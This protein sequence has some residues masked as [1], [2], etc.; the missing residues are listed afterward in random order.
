VM[1]SRFTEDR[2]GYKFLGIAIEDNKE[3][4]CARALGAL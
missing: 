2:S 1:C 4:E 3:V